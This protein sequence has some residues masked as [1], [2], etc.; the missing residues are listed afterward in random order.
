[1]S[2]ESQKRSLEFQIT[3]ILTTVRDAYDPANPGLVGTE[4]S[5]FAKRDASYRPSMPPPPLPLNRE[6][7][8]NGDSMVEDYMVIKRESSPQSCGIDENTGRVPG[9]SL[10][11]ENNYSYSEGRATGNGTSL[12]RQFSSRDDEDV[13]D[14]SRRQQD[15]NTSRSKRRGPPVD[16]A[17]G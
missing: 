3:N 15:D 2:G 13:E 17:Y 9:L 12:K 5:R 1:M 7:F 6:S 4:N 10:S 14:Q 8:G 11:T 16:E